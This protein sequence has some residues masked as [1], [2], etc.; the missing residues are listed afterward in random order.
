MVGG[1][2]C[3]RPARALTADGPCASDGPGRCGT[4]GHHSRHS[5]A[6]S[7]L[8]NSEHIANRVGGWPIV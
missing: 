1:P 3:W 5:T 2:R 6:I 7:D 8:S 4:R